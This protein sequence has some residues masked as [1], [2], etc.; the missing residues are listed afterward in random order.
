MTRPFFIVGCSRS[1]TTLLRLLLRSH[2]NLEI[3]SESHFIPLLYRAFG[4]P[5]SDEEAWRMAR[6][7]LKHP[8]VVFWNITAEKQDFS[9]CRSF[10]GVTRRLFEICAQKQG[11]PRWGDKTPEYVREI[12][13][14]VQLFPDAQVIHIVRDG[15]DVALSWLRAGYH[16][17]NLYM[18][19]SGWRERVTRGRSDGALLP[20]DTY[21]ELRY[22]GL[23]A[24][25]EATMRRVC[26][27]LNETYDPAVLRPHVVPSERESLAAARG[28]WHQPLTGVILRDNAGKWKSR[29]SLRQRALFESVAGDLLDELGYPVEGLAR[30]L[31]RGEKMLRVADHRLRFL[32]G[33]LWKMRRPYY[34]H[35]KAA[36]GWA[37]LRSFLRRAASQ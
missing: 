25:P 21:F 19:A 9:G 5:S 14:L 1:G 33:T 34:R 24:D 2:P 18:A 10:S 36:V 28:E 16:P 13:L 26:E 11:K 3:P 35:L 8:R 15:R 29:M 32:A 37:R 23:L 7:I 22:E 31:S 30:R 17:R 12:P 20:A 27:F 4:N 6:R